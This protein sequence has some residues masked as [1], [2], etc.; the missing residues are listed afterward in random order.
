[1][2]KL[3]EGLKVLDL[4]T[5]T[6]GPVA[7]SFLADYGADVI[8]IEKPGVGDNTRCKGPIL[9]GQSLT[10][11]VE[12][13][14]K[15]SVEVD[16][17]TEKGQEVVHRLAKDVDIVIESFEAGVTREIGL[18]YHTLKAINPRIIYCS[19]TPFG[20]TGYYANRDG[21]GMLGQA[22]TGL[23]YRTGEPD[24]RPKIACN[25]DLQ[26]V[27]MIQAFAALNMALI[28]REQTGEGQSVDIS[29]VRGISWISTILDYSF[30]NGRQSRRTGN[31]VITLAPYGLY[32]GNNG[33]SIIIAALNEKLW[34]VLCNVMGRDDLITH[35]NFS[36]NILRVKNRIALQDIIEGWLRSLDNINV[37][38]DLLEQAGV[39]YGKVM[40]MKDINENQHYNECGWIADMP[41]MDG[42][43]STKVRRFPADPF[44]FSLFAPEYHKAPTLGEH[45]VE[46]LKDVGYTTEE[47]QK[48]QTEWKG[49]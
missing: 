49:E 19:I 33:E 48:M 21:Y 9:D 34:A 4:T 44:N 5:R 29:I 20:R 2:S 36:S 41:V 32:H 8:H 31:N 37:A 16:V 46:V 6:P 28:W 15:K 47:I 7:A 30:H 14:G 11:C 22:M 10:C 39:P 12:N 35:P 25:G 18:D 17:F 13:R 42:I 3:Y 27:S 23:P 45:T 43:T 38:V 1:M 26:D 40:S 24:G